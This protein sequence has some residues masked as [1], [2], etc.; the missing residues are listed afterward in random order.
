M[1]DDEEED[2][3]L[4]S[5][6]VHCSETPKFK[7]AT[8]LQVKPG[9]SCRT[10]VFNK[11]GNTLY[12]ASNGGCLAAIDVNRGSCDETSDCSILWKVE[13]ASPHGIT[14][15][16]YIDHNT[17]DELLVTGDDEGVI[18]I[19][20]IKTLN[21]QVENGS[22]VPSPFDNCLEPLPTGC[23]ASFH[24]NSDYISAFQVSSDFK[25]LLA[26][27]ADGVLT[28][29]ELV[30]S[31]NLKSDT[32]EVGVKPSKSE[33]NPKTITG[34][35]QLARQSDE[36]GDELLSM[37]I[38]KGGKKVVVGSQEGVL[39]IWSWGTWGDISDRFPGHPMSIDALLKVDENTILTGSSDGVVRVVTIQPD[40]LLGVLGHHEGFPVEKLKFDGNK[41]V[42]GSVSHDNFVRVWDA[43]LLFDD[44]VNEAEEDDDE[45]K[46]YDGNDG[47][48]VEQTTNFKTADD[49]A[50]DWE[51]VEDS[52]DSMDSDDT[53]DE[54]SDNNE[55][56]DKK[57]R[58]FKTENETF[59][60]DL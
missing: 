30:K 18:R 24:E 5:I 48:K 52:D 16:S 47:E 6:P 59:F 29:I 21:G 33:L 17:H 7:C 23:L 35:F 2:T 50:D 34:P 44:G 22:N 12:S 15:L 51:D 1:K 8:A 32:S 31:D 11:S 49:S 54:D 10:I 57:G 55:R 53:D 42:L 20:S 4:S 41:K 45:M 58:K 26:T 46:D 60:E 38:L 19:W 3:I 40:K 37:V 9:P 43:S 27:S 25:T 28:V 36:Q 56:K 13:S 39:N 14:A